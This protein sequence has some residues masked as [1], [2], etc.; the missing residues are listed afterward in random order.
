MK[1]VDK[2]KIQNLYRKQIKEKRE[3]EKNFIETL[4]IIILV[5]IL[6]SISAFI[7]DR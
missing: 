6:I 5:G 2:N 4:L 3:N 1:S 7:G